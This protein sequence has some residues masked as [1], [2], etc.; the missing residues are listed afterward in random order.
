MA[1]KPLQPITPFLWLDGRAEEAM[2]FYVSVFPNSRT[3]GVTRYGEAGPGPRGSVMTATFALNGQEF[4]ALNGGPSFQF[5][6]AVS[7]VVHC[8]TQAEIDEFWGKLTAGGQEGQ[9]GWLTNRFGVSW[10]VLPNALVPMLQDPDPTTSSRVVA[11]LMPMRKPDIAT[12][13]RAYDQP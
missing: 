12:L 9:C 8:E 7:F 1:P 5:T 3:L 11:A 2:N 13:K 4:T 10:Q 6:P